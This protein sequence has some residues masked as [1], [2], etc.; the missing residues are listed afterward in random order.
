MNN[1]SLGFY[2]AL[3][4]HKGQEET[5]SLDI[6]PL[7]SRLELRFKINTL[8]AAAT[9]ANGWKQFKLSAN[10]QVF[11][12]RVKP[13]AWNKLLKAAEEL[14]RWVATITAQLGGKTTDGFELERPVVKV[15]EK[16]PKERGCWGS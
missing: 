15:F 3:N 6:Q 11:T 1:F 2:E 16:K 4:T 12:L 9:L 14:P 5:H 7:E 10:G 8:P 13:N